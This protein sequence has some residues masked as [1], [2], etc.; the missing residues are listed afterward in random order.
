[1]SWKILILE[2]SLRKTI[3]ELLKT[4]SGERERMCTRQN[5]GKSTAAN[6]SSKVRRQ[7]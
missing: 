2:V 7:R 6:Q 3:D 4:R 1:M 5:S